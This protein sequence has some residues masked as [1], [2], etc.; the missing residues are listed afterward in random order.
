MTAT[1]SVRKKKERSDKDSN[2]EEH[3]KKDDLVK[4]REYERT[5]LNPDESS[6]IEES[7]PDAQDLVAWYK[8]ADIAVPFTILNPV[9]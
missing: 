2:L 6:I 9:S 7:H 3:R 4:T 1:E 8:P 5:P